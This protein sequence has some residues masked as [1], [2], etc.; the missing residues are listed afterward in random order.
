MI[1]DSRVVH[2]HSVCTVQLFGWTSNPYL[3]IVRASLLLDNRFLMLDLHWG[4][5]VFGFPMNSTHFHRF[6][7]NLKLRVSIAIEGQRQ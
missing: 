2:W 4:Y 3:V 7:P 1:V 6:S 5:G